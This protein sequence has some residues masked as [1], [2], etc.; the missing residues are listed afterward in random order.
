MK[1]EP[2]GSACQVQL[3]LRLLAQAANSLYTDCATIVSTGHATTVNVALAALDTKGPART[4]RGEATLTFNGNTGY[5][6][7]QT[8]WDAIDRISDLVAKMESSFLHQEGPFPEG[9][10]A[11]MDTIMHRQIKEEV[12]KDEEGR[13]LPQDADFMHAV[14]KLA[15][16]GDSLLSAWPAEK[17]RFRQLMRDFGFPTSAYG[18]A[19]WLGPAS[20]ARV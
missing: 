3:F 7:I 1:F 14:E 13:G 11:I 18:S 10:E 16:S 4:N 15:E 17:A 9:T 20:D 2:E 6:A 5:V 8:R 19:K 12:R